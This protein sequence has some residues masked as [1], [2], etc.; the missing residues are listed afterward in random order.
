MMHKDVA[1]D[2]KLRVQGGDLAKVGFE[3]SAKPL[4]G[5]GGV[6]LVDFVLDLG[7]N[8]FALEV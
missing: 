4:E 2:G 5:G 3:R 1:Q 7:G 8:K 6:E